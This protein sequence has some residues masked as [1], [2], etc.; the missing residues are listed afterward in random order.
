MNYPEKDKRWEGIL[1]SYKVEDFQTL[2]KEIVHLDQ[3]MPEEITQ[4]FDLVK[5][6]IEYSYFEYEFLDAAFERT[7]INFELALRY[8]FIHET[9][10]TKKEAKERN[11]DQLINWAHRNSF[12]EVDKKRVHALRSLRNST[13]HRYSYQLAGYT[14]LD[15]IPLVVQW[16]NDLY[17]SVELR[18]ERK[19]EKRRIKKELKDFDTNG[20]I[21]HLPDKNVMVTGIELVYFNNKTDPKTYT[22]FFNQYFDLPLDSE[23]SNNEIRFLDGISFPPS[24]SI[25]CTGIDV[26]KTIVRF[27][28]KFDNK[29]LYLEKNSEKMGDHIVEWK[30]YLQDNAPI[31]KGMLTRDTMERY[32]KL[33]FRK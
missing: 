20:G 19:R 22:F 26:D 18:T 5:R 28:P 32:D 8:K 29:K 11:L 2:A 7:L 17:D 1:S 9:G 31:I 12:I 25:T 27:L 10:E 33:R 13:T 6:L 23:D 4:S 15:L 24:I 30:K 14:S 3:D 21:L 16:I